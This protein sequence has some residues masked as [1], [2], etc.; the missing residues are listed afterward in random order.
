ML[1][2]HYCVD[3]SYR[4]DRIHVFA[5]MWN[6]HRGNCGNSLAAIVTLVASRSDS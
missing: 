4:F 1:W 2:Y 3:R 6:A 5:V